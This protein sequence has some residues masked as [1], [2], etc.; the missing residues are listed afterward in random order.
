[1]YQSPAFKQLMLCRDQVW[2]NALGLVFTSCCRLEFLPL[3]LD[4]VFE[5]FFSEA[6]FVPLKDLSG[7]LLL[8]LLLLSLQL[9]VCVCVCVCVCAGTTNIM[10]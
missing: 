8:L 1:M 10:G 9:V 7:D 5:R 6:D 4:L 3:F 2:N